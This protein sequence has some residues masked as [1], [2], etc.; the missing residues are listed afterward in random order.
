MWRS[1]D[2]SHTFET[3]LSHQ[4]YSKQKKGRQSYTLQYSVFIIFKAPQI[5][6]D[7]NHSFNDIVV[8]TSIVRHI[9]QVIHIF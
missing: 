4:Q 3:I 2:L 1:F 5:F 6:Q 7:G 9:I 8:V